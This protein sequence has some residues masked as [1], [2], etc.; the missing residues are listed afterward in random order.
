MR[1]LKVGIDQEYKNLASLP[2][3][4]LPGDEVQIY[5]GLVE[6][7]RWNATAPTGNDPVIIRGMNGKP[8]MDGILSD[9]RGL[10]EFE[11][12]S[13]IV[14]D[15]EFKN[16]HQGN[17][18]SAGVRNVAANVIC[19]RLKIWNNDMGVTGSKG[20][21]G[22]ITEDCDIGFNG[23]GEQAH[24]FYLNG[25]LAVVRRSHVHHTLGGQNVKIR[26]RLAQV[27]G[28]YIHEGHDGEVE[29]VDGENTGGPEN[30]ATM[31]G[32]LVISQAVRVG[33]NDLRYIH[34]GKSKDVTPTDRAGVFYLRNNTLI[35]KS[36]KHVFVTL[37][38]PNCSMQSSENLY[39]GSKELLR[40]RFGATTVSSKSDLA[41]MEIPYSARMV[42]PLP[43]CGQPK[44]LNAAPIP[45]AIQ[46][47]WDAVK[48]AAYYKIYAIRQDSAGKPG[49]LRLTGGS[50][51]NVWQ[52]VAGARYPGRTIVYTVSAVNGDDVE[53]PM[54]ERLTIVAP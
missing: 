7:K 16:M 48:D 22:T 42:P 41:Q 20:S 11:S 17:L 34:F 31:E 50:T 35:A 3:M 49:P 1:V 38:G 46:L 9:A 24:N 47:S 19:R 39:A 8:I 32:N 15:L 53:G 13:W 14:E 36:P 40:L 33:G 21:G 25:Q 2:K 28:N 54:S 26:S 30:D 12:G 23:R 51:E 5:S 4:H 10:F 37:A 43:E 44:G 27:T 6:T 29:I 52:D 18:N 45:K